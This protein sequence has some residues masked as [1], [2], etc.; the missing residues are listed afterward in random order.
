[1]KRVSIF[2]CTGSIGK[3]TLEVINHLKSEFK[4]FALA[5]GANYQLL[6]KQ[7]IVHQPEIVV[8]IDNKTKDKLF[9]TLKS[10]TSKSTILSGEQGLNEI[11]TAKQTDI[12]VMAMSGTKGIIPLMKAIEKRKRICLSTK[13]LLVGFGKIIMSQAKKYNTEVL[14]I[15]SELVGIHQCLYWRNYNEIKRIIITASGGPFFAKKH[16]KNVSVSDA[17]NHPVWKMGKKITIDSAT[18]A[19]KGLE[20]I[21]TA[22]LFSIPVEKIEVLIHPQSIIHAMIEFIDNSVLAALSLPDMRACIQYALTFP[23][24]SK[25]LLKKIDLPSQKNLEFYL[26]DMKRFPALKL[27]YDAVKTDGIAPCVYNSANE[28]AVNQF[29]N[30]KIKFNIIPDII[31]KTLKAMPKIKYPDLYT[32]I[33]YEK[34][35]ADY[36][37]SVI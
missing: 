33:K 32:L 36:A 14:P 16:L 13:E 12:I 23:N 29:L 24:R 35:S 7:V 4:V 5:A 2:G 31:Q 26:P 10:S 20:V 21:E 1:M 27:A 15:D 28:V 18:L 30:G 17:L 8:T 22:R 6:A 11:A 3:S 25:S 19:N 37:E 9:H 34:L